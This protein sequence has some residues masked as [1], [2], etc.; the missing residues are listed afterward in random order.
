MQVPNEVRIRYRLVTF[1]PLSDR[2]PTSTLCAGGP[3]ET[4]ASPA[5]GGAAVVA[6][7]TVGDKVP[8]ST[9]CAG[10][11]GEISASTLTGST[12][13]LGGLA[14]ASEGRA[15]RTRRLSERTKLL[16][17][18]SRAI[19][20]SAATG[21]SSSN[22]TATVSSSSTTEQS[23]SVASA[24][25]A[26]AAPAAQA[27]AVP[28]AHGQNPSPV[29]SAGGPGENPTQPASAFQ[30]VD[31]VL[32]NSSVSAE[33]FPALPLPATPR[34]AMETRKDLASQ[35]LIA[36]LERVGPQL[37]EGARSIRVM[38]ESASLQ[39]SELPVQPAR[40]AQPAGQPS[41]PQG[42]RQ[43]SPDRRKDPR[44]PE[45]MALDRAYSKIVW[46]GP[47]AE[48]KKTLT[49]WFYSE[50]R[51]RNGK[52][53]WHPASPQELAVLQAG[54][55]EREYRRAL[56]HGT[57]LHQE[58]L[59][60]KL[61]AG[62]NFGRARARESGAT[63]TRNAFTALSTIPAE[64]QRQLAVQQWVEIPRSGLAY[65]PGFSPIPRFPP[66][67]SSGSSDSTVSPERAA[68]AAAGVEAEVAAAAAA[69]GNGGER[70]SWLRR[71][72]PTP[73]ESEWVWYDWTNA[74]H[75]SLSPDEAWRLAIT[76]RSE[77]G[78]SPSKSGNDEV[79]G[80]ASSAKAAPPSH[81]A[82]E[83]WRDPLVP[84]TV[85]QGIRDYVRRHDADAQ[86]AV[87][88]AKQYS[89]LAI[90]YGHAQNHRARESLISPV[91]QLV[92]PRRDQAVK[93]GTDCSR[94]GKLLLSP[95]GGVKKFMRELQDHFKEALVK[96]ALTKKKSS[97]DGDQEGATITTVPEELRLIIRDRVEGSTQGV[98]NQKA[99]ASSPGLWQ[100]RGRNAAT[101]HHS[102]MES[103]DMLEMLH[104]HG[105]TGPYVEQATIE[106]RKDP[107]H[108]KTARDQSP[109][110]VAPLAEFWE[111]EASP[112]ELCYAM[113]TTATPTE[114]EGRQLPGSS[115]YSGCRKCKSTEHL[116]RDCPHQHQPQQKATWVKCIWEEAFEIFKNAGVDT[117][118]GGIVEQQL[119]LVAPEHMDFAEGE[120]T[121]A[122]SSPGQRG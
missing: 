42:D 12:T 66:S 89:T 50:P 17:Q 97:D 96:R 83:E 57:L 76:T 65:P 90:S 28:A 15:E 48:E 94:C 41:A 73:E 46:E 119:A 63:P 75:P 59:P 26:G 93:S 91:M 6:C 115:T 107:A 2:V 29:L 27:S 110:P 79:S 4:S 44:S 118:S 62:V 58:G 23:A 121:V 74:R 92:G 37:Q 106:E 85:E 71:V 20:S 109:F 80:S 86:T 69:D 72:A 34:P 82:L 8:T 49:Q 9:L 18:H 32:P 102:L 52:I 104:N 24:G 87:A 88:I 64:A 77:S 114:V 101:F 116:A 122:G 3:G 35:E 108:L 16:I 22:T 54:V 30:H 60:R 112:K 19:V 105:V 111:E 10:G 120:S 70:S 78:G 55:T 84:I 103:F 95:A 100:E 31:F 53:L 113:P 98:L 21:Q 47:E 56:K 13:T 99:V 61:F 40:Q 68:A 43:R 7:P 38:R 11:S 45:Q 51:T 33:D 36:A 1:F 67:D 117:G 81:E 14:V 39:P 25:N 5:S